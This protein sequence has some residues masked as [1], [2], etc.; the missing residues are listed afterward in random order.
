MGHLPEKFVAALRDAHP[1]LSEAIAI[2]ESDSLKM[3][4]DKENVK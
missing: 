2:A 1:L 3:R 4:N